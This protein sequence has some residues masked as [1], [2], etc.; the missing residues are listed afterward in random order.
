LAAALNPEARKCPGCGMAMIAAGF[1]A[2]ES[3]DGHVSKQILGC[4]FRA[5]G[6]REGDIFHAGNKKYLEI[7]CD[8]V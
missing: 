4:S 7:V 3:I 8:A 1:D 6:M 2:I 5:I